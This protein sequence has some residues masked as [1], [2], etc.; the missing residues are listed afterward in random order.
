MAKKQLAITLMLIGNPLPEI[1]KEMQER[2][3]KHYQQEEV[4]I[5][6]GC[7]RV[8]LLITEL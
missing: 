3:K 7:E 8:D 5:I 6:T 4:L 2:L 1:I